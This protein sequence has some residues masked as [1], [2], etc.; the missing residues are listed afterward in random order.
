MFVM[1]SNPTITSLALPWSLHR[2]TPQIHHR[3]TQ[4][5]RAPQH[6]QKQRWARGGAALIAEANLATRLVKSVR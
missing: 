6:H 2:L 3:C 5:P 4:Q 1:F